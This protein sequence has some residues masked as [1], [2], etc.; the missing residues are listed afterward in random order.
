MSDDA[1]AERQR[2]IDFIERAAAMH[3]NTLDQFGV[4]EAIDICAAAT[5][6]AMAEVLRL[7]AHVP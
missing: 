7:G 4:H 6:T 3:R 1:L 5:L 2:I